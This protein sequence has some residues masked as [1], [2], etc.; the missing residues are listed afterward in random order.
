MRQATYTEGLSNKEFV[1]NIEPAKDNDK[2][3]RKYYVRYHGETLGWMTKAYDW[4]WNLHSVFQ[5]GDV[6]GHGIGK[7]ETL[8]DGAW[9]I[10]QDHASWLSVN[11]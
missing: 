4:G 8:D 10:A 6:V 11:S 9:T 3:Y 5:L 1:V 2:D 7:S